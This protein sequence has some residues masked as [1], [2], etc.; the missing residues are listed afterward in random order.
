[1][2]NAPELISGKAYNVNVDIWSLG[3]LA[4]EMVNGEAPYFRLA[5]VKAL[6]NIATRPPPR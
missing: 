3:I 4:I 1:M 5:A 2:L 6:Y